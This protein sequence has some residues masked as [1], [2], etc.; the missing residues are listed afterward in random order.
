MLIFY[1][2]V[3]VGIIVYFVTKF[4]AEIAINQR[5]LKLNIL[6]I[7]TILLAIFYFFAPIIWNS[8]RVKVGDGYLGFIEADSNTTNVF[9]QIIAPIIITKFFFG[10]ICRL[11][12][13][14]RFNMATQIHPENMRDDR[15][16]IFILFLLTLII[17]IFGEGNSI[18]L[19]ETYLSTNGLGV[20]ARLSGITTLASLGVLLMIGLASK[21]NLHAT[22]LS[23]LIW[24][25]FLISKGS[26]SSLLALSSLFILFFKNSRSKFRRIAIFFGYLIFFN[27]SFFIVYYSRSAPHGL[28]RFPKLFL[29]SINESFEKVLINYD[30]VQVLLG[31]I[32]FAVILIPMSV[33]TLDLVS[34]LQNANPLISNISSQTYDISSHGV[35]RLYPYI[36]I[37]TSSAG[38]IYGAAGTIALILIFSYMS[39]AILLVYKVSVES[40]FDFLR[41]LVFVTY[42][43]SLFFFLQYST[44]IWFRMFWAFNLSVF[45]YLLIKKKK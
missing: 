25:L 42:A 28:L 5:I 41:Y 4:L 7:S 3:I 29:L 15:K 39:F 38:V 8:I 9:H 26:R 2:L 19:R 1:N 37:P 43:V 6:E 14:F 33:G 24:Y 34:V 32:L 12:G 30:L 20:F 35:E 18:L 40:R 23:L 44:R 17:F 10:T 36:W 16:L 45:T 31:S 11:I 21:R 22:I 27:L 13:I